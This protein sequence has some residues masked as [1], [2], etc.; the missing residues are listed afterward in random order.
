MKP[1]KSTI[2]DSGVMKTA[3]QSDPMVDAGRTNTTKAESSGR[4]PKKLL[5]VASANV[6]TLLE[7]AKM[8]IV[9]DTYIHTYIIIIMRQDHQLPAQ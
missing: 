2:S 9:A 4:M 8:S 1:N 3:S 7:S 5:K 6:D